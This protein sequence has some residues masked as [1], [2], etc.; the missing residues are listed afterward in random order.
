MSLSEVLTGWSVPALEP[1]DPPLKRYS[2]TAD[3]LSYQRCRRQYG[4]FKVRGFCSATVTQFYFG[5]LVHDVLDRINRNYRLD[6]TLPDFE[7]VKT[8][9]AE[10]HDRL[11]RSGIRTYNARQQQQNAVTFINRFMILIGPHFF[12]NVKETEYRLERILQTPQDR[13]YILDGVVDVLSGAVSHCLGLPFHTTED[14]IEIWDYKSGKKP[15]NGSN[16]MQSY[17][18]QMKVYA[19]LY[20]QQTNSYPARCSLIFVGELGEDEIWEG[21]T[22]SLHA[23]PGLIY[24]I[25]PDEMEIQGAMDNFH[26]TVEEIEN[27]LGLP[28][29]EQWQPPDHDVDEQTCAAC[30]LRYRCDGLR[31]ANH[32]LNEPL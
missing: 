24:S 14:D 17:E 11:V 7:G 32:Q 27:E 31:Q 28:Y 10:A 16:L 29:G 23:F 15:E 21:T 12:P 20:R 2:T 9:V 19:E 4:F 22:P 30:E 3:I 1:D 25:E 13:E 5:T 26:A 18:Y 6:Q 8:L